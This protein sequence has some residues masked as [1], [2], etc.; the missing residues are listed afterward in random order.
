[1]QT[2]GSAGAVEP[3]KQR[4]LL[5]NSIPAKLPAINLDPFEMSASEVQDGYSR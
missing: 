5:D 2:A 1:M 3:S 4:K